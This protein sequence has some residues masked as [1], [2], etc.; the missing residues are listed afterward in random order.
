VVDEQGKELDKPKTEEKPEKK[1]K[2]STKSNTTTTSDT[3]SNNMFTL[4]N[5]MDNVPSLYEYQSSLRESKLK[6]QQSQQQQPAPK[7]K[8]RKAAE[9]KEN[10]EKVEKKAPKNPHKEEKKGYKKPKEEKIGPKSVA[11]DIPFWQNDLFK[12]LVY[13]FAIVTAISVLYLT[14]N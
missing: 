3:Q 9:N 14:L 2:Q 10:G 7:A 11:R 12:P 5:E 1:L 8:K 13:V 4:A 6:G